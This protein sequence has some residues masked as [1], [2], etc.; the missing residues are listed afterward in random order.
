MELKAALREKTGKRNKTARE[1]GHMP[2]VLY[3]RKEKTT[4]LTLSRAEF[5]K[6]WKKAGES[7]VVRILGLQEPKDALIHDVDFDPV[8]GVPRHADFYVFEKGQKVKVKIP[9]EFEGI[10]PAV[11]DLGGTL[12][13]VIY[14]LEVEAEP[15]KLP[16]SITVD[17]SPLSTLEAQ[18]YVKDIKLPAGVAAI[19]NGE[20]VVALVAE[21]K[22][23]KEE[24]P[25]D[26][27]A[28]EV[29]K[30]GKEEEVSAEGATAETPKEE[31]A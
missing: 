11:K 24:V 29:E 8:T 12:V 4:P 20:D 9:L 25:L 1:T 10:A 17:I 18:I 27:S 7:S 13:K 6:V 30:K 2:A 26:I 28:I 23:E 22:E 31:K 14:E 5:L 19:A 21:Y 3:G 15:G 16:H